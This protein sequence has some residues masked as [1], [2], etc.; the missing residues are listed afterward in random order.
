[1]KLA[2]AVRPLSGTRSASS[3]SAGSTTAKSRDGPGSRARPF[4]TGGGP[5]SAGRARAPVADDHHA[6]AFDRLPPCYAYLLGL[7]LGDGNITRNRRGV[8]RL[9]ITL[10]LAYPLIIATCREAM[11]EVMPTEPRVGPVPRA[12]GACVEVYSFSKH[13]PCLFPQHGPGRKHTRLIALTDWQRALCDRSPELLLRGL[14]H[15]DGCRVDQPRPRRRQAVRL[16]ALRLHQPLRRHPPHLLRLPRRPRHRVAAD[17]L[18][19]HLDCPS[20]RR[21]QTRRVHRPE[22]LT[23]ASSSS[24]IAAG[25]TRTPAGR[26][27]AAG[28]ERTSRPARAQISIPAAASHGL[29][30]RS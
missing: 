6:H 17:G 14:I 22:G 18:E 15:S 26:P 16:S 4:A 9:R 24:A 19:E 23:T 10:D 3:S 13:W 29:S 21:R 1:M 20:R 27:S 5:T 7:Y 12:T 8:Y 11:T 2:Y 28:S 25:A 30:P